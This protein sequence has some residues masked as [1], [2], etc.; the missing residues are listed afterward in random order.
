MSGMESTKF[1]C[2]RSRMLLGNNDSSVWLIVTVV[3]YL[4]AFVHSMT[5]ST[6][7]LCADEEGS[8]SRYVD[9][10]EGTA[11]AGHAKITCAKPEKVWPP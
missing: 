2:L 8:L 7:T 11:L 6:C 3:R 9:R 4:N 1:R 5:S 10:M